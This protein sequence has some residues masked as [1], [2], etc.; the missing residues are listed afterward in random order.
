M[1]NKE[2]HILFWKKRSSHTIKEII[3]RLKIMLQSKYYQIMYKS[4]KKIG[5]M[6]KPSVENM[7][8]KDI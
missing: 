7:L 1:E 8:K 4:I 5:L 3:V 2:F 6:I